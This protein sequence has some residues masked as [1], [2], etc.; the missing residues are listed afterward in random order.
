[1]QRPYTLSNTVITISYSK[2]ALFGASL[3][4]LSETAPTSYNK[5][6]AQQATSGKQAPTRRRRCTFTCSVYDTNDIGQ[7]R[8]SLGKKGQ[9]PD[10][11]PKL[12]SQIP[13][14][15]CRDVLIER[16]SV[17]EFDPP[18]YIDCLIAR[19]QLRWGR[20]GLGGLIS[21]LS[22][23]RIGSRSVSHSR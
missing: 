18:S 3:P 16:L 10:E 14:L 5:T 17:Q 8:S 22:R 6:A 19:E 23:Q 15:F 9:V 21:N 4:S 11:L 13:S 20:C 12:Q 7:I 2:V 1:M